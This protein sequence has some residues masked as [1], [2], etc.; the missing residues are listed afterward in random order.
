MRQAILGHL[1]Q[2]GN[3]SSF[4]R[5]QAI[6]LAAY[7]VAFRIEEVEKGSAAGAFIGIQGG[8]ITISSQE[9]MLRMVDAAHLRPQEQWWLDLRLIARLLS[10]PG[11]EEH[12]SSLQRSIRAAEGA[13]G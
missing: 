12:Q 5:I 2:S 11:A 6:R 8:H 13:T 10:Q 9:D 3:P 7:W 1:Q 4:D